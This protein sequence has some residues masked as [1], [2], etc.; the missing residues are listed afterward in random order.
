[1]STDANDLLPPQ[2]PEST[3]PSEA[4]PP[5]PEPIEDA[6]SRA[7]SEAL[8]SSFKIVRFLMLVLLF[9]FLISG[10]FIVRPNEVA[11]L[12]RFGK[13][14]GV[15]PDIVRG[16]GFYFAWPAPIDEVV[17]IKTG[18]S[19]T[20]RSSAGWH[21]TTPEMELAGSEPAPRGVL[22]PGSD[23]YVISADGNIFHA[24]AT[25]KYRISDPL[26][27]QF[28]FADPEALLTNILNNAIAYAAAR[29]PADVALYKDKAAYRDLV[30]ARVQ[31]LVDQINLGITLEPSDVVT[32]PPVDVR[33]AF[34]EVI[35][36]E[37]DRSKLVSDARA[38][39]DETTRRAQGEAE[40]IL[41]EA[42]AQSNR[43]VQTVE[44]LAKSF[45]E[46]LP[47]YEKDPW[48][49]RSRLLA[50]R[51]ERV[52]TNV[53]EKMYLPELPPGKK[54]ELRLQLSREPIE[55]RAPSRP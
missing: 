12:L 21:Y 3:P 14:V 28:A 17:K 30:L 29:M 13:P 8:S 20:V 34:E 24:R 38:Y 19:L 6:S 36:A 5:A 10:S 49:F 35:A 41:N 15:G 40:A 45:N 52:L 16:P 18:Q 25:L 43:F 23:G 33:A 32:K 31:E 2:P 50:D 37:Q 4:G 42:M 27:Y 1:M 53:Q 26:R 39:Y 51:L 9:V 47:E 55:R 46:M 22:S 54:R 44:S 48:L 11:V 7:L